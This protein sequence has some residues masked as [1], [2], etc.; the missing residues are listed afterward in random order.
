MNEKF[1]L[2]SEQI[3]VNGHTL[4]RIKALINFSDVKVGD[5]GGGK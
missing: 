1:E 5:I 3:K 4:H 2:T